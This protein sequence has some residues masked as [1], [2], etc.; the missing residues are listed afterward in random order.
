MAQLGVAVDRRRG[1][2]MRA[3]ATRLPIREGHLDAATCSMGMQIIEPVA[4][5]LAGLAFVLREGGRAV[6]LLPPAGRSPG[7]TQ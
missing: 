4:E 1:P 2:L 5:T 6:L 7:A 3:S